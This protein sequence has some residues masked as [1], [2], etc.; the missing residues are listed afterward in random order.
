[1]TLRV[2]LGDA[3]SSLS[4]DISLGDVE[5]QPGGRHTYRRFDLRSCTLSMRK[6]ARYTPVLA[7]PNRVVAKWRGSKT[8]TGSTCSAAPFFTSAAALVRH[9]SERRAS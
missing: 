4:S 5:G 3:N 2:T 7:E 6:R 8:Y 1:V 9:W